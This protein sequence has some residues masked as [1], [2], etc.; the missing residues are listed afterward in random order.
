MPQLFPMNWNL[1]CI[2]F[3]FTT[4]WTTLILYFNKT[5]KLEPLPMKKSN[6][7]KNWKW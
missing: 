4:L 2:L 3:T 6:F 7:Q 5:T 1:L